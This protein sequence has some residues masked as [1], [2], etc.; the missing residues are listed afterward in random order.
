MAVGQ[1]NCAAHGFEQTSFGIFSLRSH[2]EMEIHIRLIF[3]CER[4]IEVRLR[5]AKNSVLHAAGYTYNFGVLR[6]AVSH[7]H[8]DVLAQC[9]FTRPKAGGSG[10]IQNCHRRI[11][12]CKRPAAQQ[13]D[14]E[15]LEIRFALDVE[16]GGNGRHGWRIAGPLNV[17]A[18]GKHAEGDRAGNAHRFHARNVFQPLQERLVDLAAMRGI[19]A[20]QA[21]IH[22]D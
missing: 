1:P 8:A 11:R 5:R 2:F 14:S 20:R 6:F 16:A 12:R 18:Q 10:L 19:V 17:A 7:D 15:S 9:V 3:L 4:H 22:L 21:R 13:R